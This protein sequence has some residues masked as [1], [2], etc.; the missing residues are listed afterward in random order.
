MLSY[1]WSHLIFCLVHNPTSKN[2]L[3]FFVSHNVLLFFC[4]IKSLKP[5]PAK[6]TPILHFWWGCTCALNY[7]PSYFFYDMHV[8]V[9]WRV[10][11]GAIAKKRVN[12]W[13][14]RIKNWK[15]DYRDGKKRLEIS[16]KSQSVLL[17]VCSSL[18]RYHCYFKGLFSS[19]IVCIFSEFCYLP[20]LYIS[21]FREFLIYL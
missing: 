6:Y 10:I 7:L 5:K 9:E 12:K 15:Y 13:I 20:F 3:S 4:A 17:T 18:G 19:A 11:A 21:Q 2:F 16:Y 14:K 8:L 1:P